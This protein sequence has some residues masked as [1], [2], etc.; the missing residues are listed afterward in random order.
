MQQRSAVD[1]GCLHLGELAV[2][3][4]HHQEVL[5]H[6]HGGV[7]TVDDEALVAV[8]G[9]RIAD[10]IGSTYQILKAIA[11]QNIGVRLVIQGVNEITLI[12]GVDEKDFEKTVECLYEYRQKAEKEQSEVD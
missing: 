12:V 2:G 9:Q 1:A 11:D 10:V 3:T 4:E 8:V 7:G 5:G 6:G